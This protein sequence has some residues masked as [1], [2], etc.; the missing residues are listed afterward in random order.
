MSDRPPIK[1]ARIDTS[2]LQLNS[3]DKEFTEFGA[4]VI[5][6]LDQKRYKDDFIISSNTESE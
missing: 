5:S 3:K 1:K 4:Q 2:K 6:L